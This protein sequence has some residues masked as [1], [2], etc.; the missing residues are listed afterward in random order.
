MATVE[1][2]YAP[3]DSDLFEKLRAIRL[4]VCDVDGVFSDGRIYMG[5]DGEELKAFH[6][7]DGYG[8][9]AAMNIGIEVAIV[10]GRTSDI[11]SNRMSALGVKHILQGREEKQSAVAELQK[12]LKIKVEQTASIGDDVPDL[13]M[14]SLSSVSVCVASGH[15]QVKQKA[16]YTTIN[17]GG[18]GAVREFCDL[19]LQAQGKLDIIHGASI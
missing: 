16:D 12:S 15:P 6:T 19:L 5:N 1:T 11:V 18:F 4:L 8:I 10:T 3:V 9:K 14:F 13:A 7:L 2:L 17:R